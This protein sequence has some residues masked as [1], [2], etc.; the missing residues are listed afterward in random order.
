MDK[1]RK[2]EH[3]Q[4]PDGRVESSVAKTNNGALYQPRY[5]HLLL[6]FRRLMLSMWGEIVKALLHSSPFIVVA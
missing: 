1:N 3:V 2:S 4:T 5:L 6:F